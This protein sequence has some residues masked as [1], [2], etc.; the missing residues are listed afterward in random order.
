[1]TK[2]FG[3]TLVVLLMGA[4]CQPAPK[5]EFAVSDKPDYSGAYK[6][7]LAKTAIKLD[8]GRTADGKAE[9]RK[10]IVATAVPMEDESRVFTMSGRYED[11]FSITTVSVTTAGD[12]RMFKTVG[13]DVQS[14]VEDLIKNVGGVVAVLAPLVFVDG[15]PPPKADLP[16]VIEISSLLTMT[17]PGEAKFPG[18]LANGINYTLTV[19]PVA[20]DA[21]I[22]EQYLAS[23][24]FQ[25][26][27]SV[28]FYSACRSASLALANF[29]SAGKT[30]YYNFK[31]ADPKFVQTIALPTKGSVTFHDT[32]GVDVAQQ[33]SDAATGDKI[34]STL[35][36]QV[37]AIID[38]KNK[39]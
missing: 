26:R 5:V 38:A 4:A 29:P 16:D 15:A 28:L 17:H 19:D 33:R 25:S 21:I 1:M 18:R 3:V 12:T 13:S 35:V 34:L 37:K 14:K 32:C 11:L 20:K 31:I 36:S 9:D 6:F 30:T 2:L 8:Y 24:E 23:R 22:T 27:G 7:T 10:K 39:K